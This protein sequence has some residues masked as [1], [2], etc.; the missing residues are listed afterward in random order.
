MKSYKRTNNHQVY[1]NRLESVETKYKVLTMHEHPENYKPNVNRETNRLLLQLQ[2]GLPKKR[3]F[4][5]LPNLS[6][7]RSIV[8]DACFIFDNKYEKNQFVVKLPCGHVF[9]FLPRKMAENRHNMSDLQIILVK[10]TRS[11][12][13]SNAFFKMFSGKTF[14]VSNYFI[15]LI[16]SSFV[17]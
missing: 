13:V 11:L 2:K 16:F 1:L 9:R 5:K 17:N 15:W 14:L 10:L 12:A 8:G 7:D 3:L 4:S 6:A